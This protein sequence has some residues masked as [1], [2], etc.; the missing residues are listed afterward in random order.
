MLQ[1]GRQITRSQLRVGQRLQDLSC[2]TASFAYQQWRYLP[3]NAKQRESAA[4]A[5][6]TATLAFKGERKRAPASAG[7]AVESLPA[8]GPPA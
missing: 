8:H 3:R 5:T 6:S 1:R 4:R 7:D 2:F